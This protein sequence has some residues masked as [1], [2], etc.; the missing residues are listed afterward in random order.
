VNLVGT[1]FE[2]EKQDTATSIAK[3]G[4]SVRRDDLSLGDGL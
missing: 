4:V 3:L 2:F 1:G